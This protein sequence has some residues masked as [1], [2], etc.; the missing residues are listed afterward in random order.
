MR[1]K[2][3]KQE[4]RISEIVVLKD[5]A[6]ACR[7]EGLRRL[8]QVRWHE[9]RARLDRAYSF[10]NMRVTAADINY[11][12]VMGVFEFAEW[13]IEKFLEAEAFD[14]MAKVW[15]GDACKEKGPSK[16]QEKAS[17]RE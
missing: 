2:K 13:V 4:Q 14:E 8:Q 5:Q 9:V 17:S 16:V 12:D 11:V 3:R 1:K 15:R 6:E 7:E 10:V